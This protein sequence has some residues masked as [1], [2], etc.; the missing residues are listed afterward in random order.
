MR[1]G[2]D[3][4]DSERWWGGFKIDEQSQT[5]ALSSKVCGGINLEV[6]NNQQKKGTYLNNKNLANY[7]SAGEK[8]K[9]KKKLMK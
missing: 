2:A 3:R 7:F 9:K 8:K 6:D 5:S 4:E 1:A